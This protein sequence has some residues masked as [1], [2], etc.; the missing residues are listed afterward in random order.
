M[1]KKLHSVFCLIYGILLI[2]SFVFPTI[3]SAQTPTCADGTYCALSTIPGVTQ[4]GQEVN[5]SYIVKNIYGI[6]I[7]IAAI[8][9]VGMIIWAGIQYA[10]TEA[11]TGKSD[12]KRHWMGAI[13][14]LLLL[15][16][17]YILLRTININLVNQNLDLGTPTGCTETGANG[18]T[19]PCGVNEYADIL[20][21]TR[22][23]LAAQATQL[24][25]KQ[26][27]LRLE[28]ADLELERSNLEA[29]NKL[30][31]AYVLQQQIEAKETELASINQ[32]FRINR[33]YDVVAH[34]SYN[35]YEYFNSAVGDLANYTIDENNKSIFQTQLNEVGASITTFQNRV[36]DTM[37]AIRNS[38]TSSGA[39][40]YTQEQ[41]DTMQA[42]FNYQ[43]AY[44]NNY[45][46][47]LESGKT[48]TEPKK[49]EFN[50]KLTFPDQTT[51]P[52]Q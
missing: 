45:K 22:E 29:Q 26:E 11:I 30:D 15:L 52:K 21:S 17:S 37:T 33:N 46:A 51:T 1:M 9:A 3:A 31:E 24:T 42:Q 8:L 50:L 5:P 44:M 16:S 40:L 28:I 43:L 20:K 4:A 34:T 48:G 13:G 12:A 39:P 7:A 47:W 32:D 41:I 49:P 19:Q 27:A 2:S 35:G 18:E 38:Q 25:Q 23:A 36:T 10:T 6:S 14:G